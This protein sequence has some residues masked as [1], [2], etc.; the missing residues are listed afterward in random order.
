MSQEECEKHNVPLRNRKDKKGKYCPV[1]I[2]RIIRPGPSKKEQADMKTT[3]NKFMRKR[4]RIWTESG[5]GGKHYKCTK[6][7]RRRR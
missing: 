2:Q 4:H 5:G 6:R 3:R 1:C 7:K